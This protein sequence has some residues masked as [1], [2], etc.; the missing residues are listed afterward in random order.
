[1][2]SKFLKVF[3]LILCT[4]LTAIAIKACSFNNESTLKPFKVGLNSWPGY[5][6]ALYAKEAGLF[7]KRGLDVEF[8]RFINQ[9]DNIRAT[10]R[11]AQDV[12]FVPLPEVM[13]VDSAEEKPVFVMVVDISAGSDG[14]AAAPKIKS[15]KDLKGKKVSAKLSTVSH[16]VL[17]EALKA[18]QLKPEDIEIVDVINERGANMLKKG[19]ISASTLWEPLMTDTAKA[20]GGK[21]IHTTADVDSVVI[22]GVATRSSIVT[23]KQDE[24][25]SFIETWFEVMKAVETKPQEVFASVAKQLGMTTEAFAIDYKGLKKGD[26]AMNR[27]MF[28]G[29]RLKE[30]YQQT[31]QLLLADPRHG[32]NIREDVEI[33]GIAVTKASK[34]WQ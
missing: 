26:L 34:N 31:R 29:G 19:D 4:C 17:L 13:Q 3:A 25:V 18:N 6:I 8:I 12:S 15:V 14:I 5:Q 2:K 1:M 21:V 23:T 27:R 32:R 28:E 9:Q 20:V 10:M 30:A 24:L 16:L 22:D 33:N 11:G 7:R